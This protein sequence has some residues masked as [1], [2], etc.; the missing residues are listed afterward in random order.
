MGPGHFLWALGASLGREGAV[1]LLGDRGLEGPDCI[2]ATGG[3]SEWRQQTVGR[4]GLTRGY[5]GRKA[6]STF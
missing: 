3:G 2:W 5:L 1:W 4:S 6:K